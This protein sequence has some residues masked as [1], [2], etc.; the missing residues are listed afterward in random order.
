M[1]VTYR[2]PSEDGGST[3]SCRI[4]L[5]VGIMKVFSPHLTVHISI[6]STD[7][8]DGRVEGSCTRGL[9]GGR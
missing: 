9:L 8:D 6:N 1:H 4:H 3:D 5:L 7:D 2:G